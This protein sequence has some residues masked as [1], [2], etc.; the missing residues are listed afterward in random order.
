MKKLG[1]LI[2]I[3]ICSVA[4]FGQEIRA[5]SGFDPITG[6]PGYIYR[7]TSIVTI[8]EP[9]KYLTG[10]TTWGNFNDTAR[11]AISLT[12][13]G[14]GAATYSSAT[15]VLNIPT[16]SSGLSGSGVATRI[17]F[18]N[19]TSSITSDTSFRFSPTGITSKSK[20][21]AG[22]VLK[23]SI[24]ALANT[25]TILALDL[26]PAY[27]TSGFTGVKQYSIKI[28]NQF[29][30]FDSLNNISIG[31]GTAAVISS[32]GSSIFMGNSAGSGA[33]GAFRSN[34]FGQSAGSG[35]TSASNSNF[36]GILA[37]SGATGSNNSNFYGSNAG[38][39]ATSA[40]NSNFFG[41]TA[42]QNAS[43]AGSSNFFGFQAGFNATNAEFSNFLGSQAGTTATSANRSNFMGA[44]AGYEGTG[45]N[46]SNFL[47]Y[48]AGYRATGASNS[49]FIGPLAGEGA[50]T[51]SYSTFLGYHVGD[52]SAFNI[53]GSNNI[54]IGQNITL[55]TASTA[56]S[57]NIGNVLYGLNTYSS[58]ALAPRSVQMPLGKIGVGVQVPTAALHLPSA[59]GSI[60]GTAPLKFTYNSVA[61]TAASGTGTEA[62]ITFATQ[63]YPIF[64]IGSTIVVAGVTPAG[65]NGTVVVTASTTTSVSYN[66]AT[67]GVQTVAG[68]VSQ[69]PLLAT[70]EN[71]AV[72]YDG[73]QYYGTS[74]GV[75]YALTMLVTGTAAPATTPPG[76]GFFF[77]DTV[78]SKLYVSIATGSSADWI[79]LN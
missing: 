79:I 68:T 29:L 10:Y 77:L 16:P 70:P 42:G 2:V 62:T 15:G 71:G 3:L 30:Y 38:N 31:N 44:Q 13:T 52:S 9:L 67:T 48:R 4:S 50:T 64:A 37:G 23:N 72:E 12:T 54:M 59:Q 69:T 11:A 35:A 14:S 51:A 78:N 36:F 66:N 56:N 55:P 20:L 17:T 6:R 73:T 47:G 28:G 63:T 21:Q 22:M 19:G 1:F 33:T 18:W 57:I 8:N 58:P 26:S 46:A 25:D 74:G 61:T 43:N 40:A 27:Y 65:Y 75:R 7:D 32:L 49:I 45:A 5:L 41:S 39:G 53:T 24:S 34:F 76:V 60:A